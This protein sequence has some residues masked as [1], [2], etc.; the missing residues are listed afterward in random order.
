MEEFSEDVI[1]AFVQKNADY[2]ITKWKI[3]AATDSKVSWNWPA[4][5]FGGFWMLYRKMYLYFFIL[6]FV[7]LIV[8]FI[9]FINFIASLAM[10]I[11]LGVFGNYLY[12]KFTYDKLMKLKL[13]HKD[14]ESLKLAASQAGGTSVLAVVIAVIIIF[15]LNI[16]FLALLML[17]SGGAAPTGYEEW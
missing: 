11:G 6:L 2:Y 14:E 12:A 16:L 7:G 17:A 10:W 9:P 15:G 1:R 4:F 13:M 8:G 3:M 5:L